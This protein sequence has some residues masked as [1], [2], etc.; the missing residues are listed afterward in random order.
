[1]STPWNP[2]YIRKSKT[3]TS[4]QVKARY[5]RKHY[6]TVSFR[7]GKGSNEA[8][9]MLAEL[10]G[11]SKAEYLRHLII[12]DAE[13]AAKPEIS[14]ILGGGGN[15]YEVARLLDMDPHRLYNRL[16]GQLEFER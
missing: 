13:S 8:I 14:A 1:M 5:N 11:M 10:R 7:A 15:I 16:G 3:H 9:S 6:D 12:A 2:N 4:S